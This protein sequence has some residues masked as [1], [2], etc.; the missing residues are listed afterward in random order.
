MLSLGSLYTLCVRLLWNS[1]YC[2]RQQS[3]K[4]F[5]GGLKS[6]KLR[7]SV[8]H[9]GMNKYISL[10]SCI[11]NSFTSWHGLLHSQSIVHGYLLSTHSCGIRILSAM[12]TESEWCRLHCQPLSY[13]SSHA[14]L[15]GSGPYK[16]IAVFSYKYTEHSSL[17][18]VSR[19][20]LI[21]LRLASRASLSSPFSSP[22]Y[23]GSHYSAFLSC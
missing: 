3:L 7:M 8:Q 1:S 20:T 23:V 5:G 19:S 13:W 12:S 16:L 10:V 17:A 15:S 4:A 14:D 9:L 18:A 6:C 22:C 21:S 11:S 2:C